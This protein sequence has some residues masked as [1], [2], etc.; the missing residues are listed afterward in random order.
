[1]HAINTNK[2][3]AYM[4]LISGLA[5]SIVAEY[6]SIVG[7][8]AIF[9]A[10]VI[11]TVIMGITLGLGKVSA[12]LWLKNNW[13]IA[14]WAQRIYLFAAI[15][16]LMLITAMGA[17]GFLSKAH[18]DQSLVTGDVLSKIAVYD[19]KI[20]I[21]KEN[22]DANRKVLK[23]MDEALDAVLSRSTTETGADKAV[24]IR[25]S[26]QK[27]RARLTSEIAAEQKTISRLSEERAPIAAEVR[28][29]EAEVGPIKYIA[30]F[31]YGET[32]PAILEKAVTWIIILIIIVFDPLAVMLLIAS[33]V[34]F[35][36]I[37]EAEGDSPD[38]EPD[39]VSTSTVTTST[40]FIAQDVAAVAPEAV[41]KEESKA[42]EIDLIEMWNKV[43]AAA[44]GKATEPV[45]LPAK[46]YVWE[47]T[48]YPPV[49][50][51]GYVQNEEQME[52][53]R[54]KN[55]TEST[56]ISEKDYHAAVEKTID[57]MVDSVRK[58]ILPFYKVPYEIQEQVKQKLQDGNETN[59]NNTP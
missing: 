56:Q 40:G 26:Q 58:G 4:A 10:A 32:D 28:K 48:V 11:P 18:S 27:E 31:V 9:S 36:K 15:I 6:Y 12:T 44:E 43:L 5:L 16:I 8:T 39:V 55:I 13:T 14:S 37:R 35:Q 23:Q 42:Q 21:S 49:K 22:I 57:E 17:F 3:I 41:A 53:N 46:P 54:W 30:Q 29:V 47:T 52:S 38:K 7:L 59:T 51:E 33:Q 45:T 19:E 50:P 34:S 1:M 2:L 25:R 24:A 20:K